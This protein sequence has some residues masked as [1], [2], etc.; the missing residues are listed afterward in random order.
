VTRTLTTC[1]WRLSCTVMHG[2]FSARPHPLPQ[3]IHR[4]PAHQE[5]CCLHCFAPRVS[6]K[7]GASHLHFCNSLISCL[8]E[9]LLPTRRSMRHVALGRQRPKWNTARGGRRWRVP[10]DC[11]MG[12]RAGRSGGRQTAERR[13]LRKKP[14]N[15]SRHSTRSMRG[16]SC[17]C[18]FRRRRRKVRCGAPHER[19]LP[20]WNVSGSDPSIQPPHQPDRRDERQHREH[21]IDARLHPLEP[22]EAVPWLIGNIVGLHAVG[23]KTLREGLISGADF[24]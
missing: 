24:P 3:P 12:S 4:C 22:P 21:H 23:L 8:H 2:L 17:R 6:L 14:S 13:S 5:P 16:G 11:G 19:S 20:A 1:S 9:G 7:H 10:P 15:A 18:A